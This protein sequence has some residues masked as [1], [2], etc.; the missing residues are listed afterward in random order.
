MRKPK[1][2]MPELE[3][4]EIITNDFF[5]DAEEFIKRQKEYEKKIKEI[6][7]RRG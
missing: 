3:H 5:R 7:R 1:Y 4:L 6:Q 2:T